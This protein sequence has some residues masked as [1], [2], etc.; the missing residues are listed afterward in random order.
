MDHTLHFSISLLW[1]IPLLLRPV[2]TFWCRYFT[3]P[4]T[5]RTGI[6]LA[7]THIAFWYCV[8]WQWQWQWHWHV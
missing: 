8:P 4:A 7:N 2:T 5:Y 1:R 6:A 3:Y